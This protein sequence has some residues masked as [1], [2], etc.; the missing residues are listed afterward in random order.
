ME[1][2][3]AGLSLIGVCDIDVVRSIGNDEFTTLHEK[4]QFMAKRI[5]H[6]D[7]WPMQIGSIYGPKIDLKQLISIWTEFLK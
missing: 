5:N 1:D 7:N 4:A 3:F 6:I 2:I